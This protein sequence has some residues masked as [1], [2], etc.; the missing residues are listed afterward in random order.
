MLTSAFPK[1]H[2]VAP[3]VVAPAVVLSM[4]GI[5]DTHEYPLSICR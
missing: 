1:H 4:A 5:G 2:V 3:L